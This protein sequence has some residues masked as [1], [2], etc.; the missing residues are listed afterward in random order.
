MDIVLEFIIAVQNVLAIQ[1]AQETAKQVFAMKN[2][3]TMNCVK[4]KVKN[5]L[6]KMN[7]K[8]Y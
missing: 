6:M 3:Q 4:M 5:R 1:Y 2:V 8:N 7:L